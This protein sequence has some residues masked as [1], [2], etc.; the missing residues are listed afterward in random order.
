M[1]ASSPNT[2]EAEKSSPCERKVVSDERAIYT[3]RPIRRPQKNAYGDPILYD[4]EGARMGCKQTSCNAQPDIYKAPEI[5]METEWGRP[6][7][8]WNAACVV[9]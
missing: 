5:L 8:V 1:R 2:E 9:S 4:F 6:I 7:E 3:S